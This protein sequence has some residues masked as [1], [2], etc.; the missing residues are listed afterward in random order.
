MM[1]RQKEIEGRERTASV[2]WRNDVRE[3]ERKQEKTQGR[4]WI[5]RKRNGLLRRERRCR[6]HRIRGKE[7][8]KDS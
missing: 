7:G 2:S 3:K 4:E 1:L 5:Q 6:D 8:K